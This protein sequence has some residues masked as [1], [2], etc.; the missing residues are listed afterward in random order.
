MASYQLTKE[1]D[2]STTQSFDVCTAQNVQDKID[3]TKTN[4]TKYYSNSSKKQNAR[5]SREETSNH[6]VVQTDERK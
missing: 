2:N 4:R 5:I 6:E 1:Q 3:T